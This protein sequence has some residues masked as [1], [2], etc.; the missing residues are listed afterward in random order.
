MEYNRRG[1]LCK[2]VEYA[3]CT[4]AIDEETQHPDLRQDRAFLEKLKKAQALQ[5][6]SSGS[7]G[8]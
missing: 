8:S 2:A 7:K 6:K 3:R 4:V 5:T 1:D